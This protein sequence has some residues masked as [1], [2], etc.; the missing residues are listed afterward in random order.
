MLLVALLLSI[1]GVSASP[2]PYSWG[3]AVHPSEAKRLVG[4]WGTR[5][6]IDGERMLLALLFTPEGQVHKSISLR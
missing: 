5:A 1:K 4:L 6:T 2:P 3:N